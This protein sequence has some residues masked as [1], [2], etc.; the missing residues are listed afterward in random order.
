[1]GL[2]NVIIDLLTPGFDRGRRPRKLFEHGQGAR[3]QI[4]GINYEATR[5]QRGTAADGHLEQVTEL[6]LRV[7]GTTP[8]VCG[9]EQRLDP[10]A[11]LRLGEIVNV[12]V[13]RDRAVLAPEPSLTLRAQPPRWFC[14]PPDAGIQDP[15]LWSHVNSRR[16]G[17]PA[18]ITFLE[19]EAVTGISGTKISAR[20]LVQGAGFDDFETR[21]DDVQ[22]RPY[23]S[24]LERL[25]LRL[26]GWARPGKRHEFVIDWAS[27][28]NIDSG[29]GQPPGHIRQLIAGAG[30]PTS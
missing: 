4:V 10:N 11:L 25:N 27:A 21:S 3:A 13:D 15:S 30:C 17:L 14:S 23:S 26:P 29:L 5:P 19:C 24:H 28:A 16:D 20:A 12:H 9:V 18:T 6:A 22:L 8:W 2:S 1:M 7:G